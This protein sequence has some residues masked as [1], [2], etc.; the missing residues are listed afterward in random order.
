MVSKIKKKIIKKKSVKT[1]KQNK[2]RVFKKPNKKLIKKKVI[3]KF[4]QIKNNLLV[5]NYIVEIKGII[6]SND[7]IDIY[8]K[9]E[10]E[11]NAKKVFIHK[12]GIV[13]GKISAQEIGVY[14]KC[15]ADLYVKTSCEIFNTATIK[16]NINYDNNIIIHKGSNILG[17]L[18]PKKKPLALPDYTKN[19]ET[20]IKEGIKKSVNNFE[21]VLDRKKD[22]KSLDNIISK[23]FK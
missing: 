14:G 11:I 13:L 23:I 8:G 12:S 18:I 17:E 20:I 10:G 5:I 19:K 4:P 3:K 1:K 21:P 15:Y 2:N 22:V 7:T 6:N 16:G 9:V